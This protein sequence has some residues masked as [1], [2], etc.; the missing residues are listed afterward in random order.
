MAVK[1]LEPGANKH[2]RKGFIDEI[3][4]I[5]IPIKLLYNCHQ[6]RMQDKSLS[7]AELLNNHVPGKRTCIKLKRSSEKSSL[8]YKLTCRGYEFSK[9]LSHSTRRQQASLLEG[10]IMITVRREDVIN[11]EKL[12]EESVMLREEIKDLK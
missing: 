3:C 9:R 6:Q 7:M 2:A 1:I 4:S 8:D 12:E 5:E 11:T 10:S